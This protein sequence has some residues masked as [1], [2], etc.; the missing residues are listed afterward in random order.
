VRIRGLVGLWLRRKDPHHP[1][2]EFLD[3]NYHIIYIK[4][5]QF[6]FSSCANL[7]YSRHYWKSPC[8]LYVTVQKCKLSLALPILTFLPIIVGT[9]ICIKSFNPWVSYSFI[10]DLPLDLVWAHYHCWRFYSSHIAHLH[11]QSKLTWIEKIVMVLCTSR[12]MTLPVKAAVTE[13]RC[14]S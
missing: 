10:S 14:L 3:S 13:Q 11:I 9:V 12:R 1:P 2:V 5:Y 4:S 6:T 7:C 8:D